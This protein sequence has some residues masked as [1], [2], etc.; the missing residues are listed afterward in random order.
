M[1]HDTG[2]NDNICI[3]IFIDYS[4]DLYQ[5]K[6]FSLAS[7]IGVVGRDVSAAPQYFIQNGLTHILPLSKGRPLDMDIAL[8][9]L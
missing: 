7:R 4:V 6:M 8:L 9:R 2:G 3:I 1:I 5:R